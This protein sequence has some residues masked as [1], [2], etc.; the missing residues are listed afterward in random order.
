MHDR[1]VLQLLI[2]APLFGATL[3]PAPAASPVRRG[4]GIAM[5]VLLGLVSVAGEHDFMSRSRARWELVHRALARGVPAANLDGGFEFDRPPCYN[6]RPTCSAAQEV[7]ASAEYTVRYG[8]LPGYR[9]VDAQG[10]RLWLP[11]PQHA[12]L[13]LQ[14]QPASAGGAR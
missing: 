5:I 9:Q 11:F 7:R 3:Q 4:A 14:R 1:Y 2:L 6:P 13:L 10:Y 8:T 12:V